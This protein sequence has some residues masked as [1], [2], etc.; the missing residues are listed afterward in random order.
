MAEWYMWAVG[1]HPFA[2]LAVLLL[3][4]LGVKH[5]GEYLRRLFEAK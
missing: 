1:A 5:G 4:V 2:S 3:L